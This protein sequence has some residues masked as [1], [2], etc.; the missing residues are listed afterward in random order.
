MMRLSNLGFRGRLLLAMLGLVLLSSISIAGLVMVYLFEDEQN[1]AREQL[2]VARAISG[3]VLERRTDLLLNG[4]SIV[5]DDFGFKSAVATGD[6]ATIRSMLDN[7]VK[8]AGADLAVLTTFEGSVIA[9]SDASYSSDAKTPFPDLL[10]SALEQG[11]ASDILM[12]QNQGYQMLVVPVRGP[13]L[14]AWLFA[15]FSLGQD[16][17]DAIA[18][19]AGT[20]VLFQ[21]FSNATSSKLLASTLPGVWADANLLTK[22]GTLGNINR[23]HESADYFIRAVELG[24]TDPTGT[25]RVLLLSSRDAA[26][27]NYYER[28][29]EVLM[30]VAVVVIIAVVLVLATARALGRPVL[31]LAQYAKTIGDGNTFDPSGIRVAGELGTLRDA[32]VGMRDKILNREHRIQYNATHDDSTGLPNRIAMNARLESALKE[33]KAGWLIGFSILD[34]ADINDTLGLDFGDLVLTATGLRLRGSI[35]PASPLGRTSG[36]EFL[37]ILPASDE[38]NVRAEAERL[39]D[40]VESSQTIGDTPIAIK[41]SVAVLKIP[42]EAGDIDQ[43]RRRLNLTLAQARRTSGRIAFYQ[44]GK[45]ETRLRELQLIRD[46][47]IGLDQGQLHMNY[48]PKVNLQTVEAVQVEALV[49]WIHPTLGFISP[50]EF[51]LLA[52]RS[53]QI[54]QLTRYILHRIGQDSRLWLSDYPELGIAI[55]LSAIDLVYPRLLDDIRSAFA[56]WPGRMDQLTFEVTESAIMEDPEKARATLD[57]LRDLGAGLSVD[58]FGT[59]YSSL[60]QLRMLPVQELKIDKSFVLKLDSEPKDQLI[61]RSTIEMAHGLGLTVVAEGIEN[62]DSWSLLQTWGCDKAQ[63]YFM[64]R[65]LPAEK[66]GEWVEEFKLKRDELQTAPA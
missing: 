6:A 16:L 45:D 38:A 48:Q 40:V 65:P 54:T 5:A 11:A 55:N 53:G 37:A 14:R 30:L 25:I 7:H 20:D 32:L 39:R 1:R 27:Q 47:K 57:R 22:L 15:G 63:G 17:A 42:E 43:V 35:D 61:V 52:E 21:H 62:Q 66:L 2:N 56:D 24:G 12:W 51:I 19:L 9:S 64:A 59:G 50:E 60:A 29:L 18:S 41:C 49:R 26:W 3:E 46:L 36:N 34:F 23:L 33:G 58:D 8:R 13:G 31:D 28:I 4:L 44:S 10:E